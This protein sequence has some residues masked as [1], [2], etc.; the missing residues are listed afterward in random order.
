MEA[1]LMVQS[2]RWRLARGWILAAALG[3]S[4]SRGYSPRIRP[5][6]GGSTPIPATRPRPSSA[7][8]PDTSGMGSGR[9]RSTSTSA[10]S[11][12]KTR[13]RTCPRRAAK[14][15]PSGISSWP[16]MPAS[17]PRRGWPRCLPKPGRCI[18]RGSTPRPSGSIARGPPIATG[19]PSRRWSIRRSPRP[20]ETTRWTSSAT[21]PSRTASSAR[22]WRPIGESSPTARPGPPAWSIPTPTWTWPGSGPRSCCAGRP[23]GPIRPR[24]RISR[25]SR[26]CIPRPRA[27][28]PAGPAR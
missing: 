27:D 20:G 3:G 6:G 11:R 23:W 21:S 16:S 5:A 7:R 17:M 28:S 2:G 24:R 14:R 12:G 18:G 4:P 19:R 26:R 25:R 9:R 8:R 13:G 1:T 15:P 22:R 10:S